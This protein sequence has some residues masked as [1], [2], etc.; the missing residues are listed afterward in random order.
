MI[1]L[2]FLSI[3]EHSVSCEYP[4]LTAYSNASFYVDCMDC[5]DFFGLGG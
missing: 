2:P 3:C 1:P 5:P 4:G